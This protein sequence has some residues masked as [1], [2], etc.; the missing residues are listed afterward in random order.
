MFSF[1]K[2]NHEQYIDPLIGIV[3]EQY[4]TEFPGDEDVVGLSPIFGI[5]EIGKKSD[6]VQQYY[7]FMD[8]V[9]SYSPSML[10][11]TTNAPYLSQ[12]LSTLLKGITEI[13]LIMVNKL[14]VSDYRKLAT[15]WSSPNAQ[16]PEE[17]S[18]CPFRVMRRSATY[19]CSM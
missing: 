2:N 5:H 13:P 9:V 10:Y 8:L 11:S 1:N 7:A 16:I 3:T 12:Y 4:Y 18:H 17:V 15:V 19:S 14:C 6:T